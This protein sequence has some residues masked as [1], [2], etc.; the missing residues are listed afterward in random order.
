MA[1][2]LRSCGELGGCPSP[3]HH[4]RPPW[5]TRSRAGP[6]SGKLG[7]GG[8][9]A[10]TGGVQEGEGGIGASPPELVPSKPDQESEDKGWHGSRKGS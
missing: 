6:S 4:R 2:G 1:K 10:N 3:C 9:P 8:A 5:R 7:A